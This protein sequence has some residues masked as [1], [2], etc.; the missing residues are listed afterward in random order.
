MDPLDSTSKM[1]NPNIVGEE[2]YNVT[3][4]VQ[5]LLQDYKSLQDI[6]TILGMDELSAEDKVTVERARKVQ[7]FLSQPFFMSEVF[8]GQPGKFVKLE[9]SISGFKSLLSGEGD[10]YN[11]QSFFMTGTFEEGVEKGKKLAMESAED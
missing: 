10:Q 11:E 9:E 7:K 5:K 4:D 8:S 6:I 1:L 2:H 3:R